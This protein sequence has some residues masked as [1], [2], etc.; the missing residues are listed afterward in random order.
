MS[1]S[2]RNLL[3]GAAAVAAQTFA[4]GQAFGAPQGT[5]G[6]A[7]GATCN[8]LADAILQD[9]PESATF[10]GLDK[11]TRAGLKSRLSDQSWFHVSK[12]RD[13]CAAWLGK[14]DAIPQARLSPA[15]QVDK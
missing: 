7:F 3:T 11:G 13:V 4:F 1:P 6:A 2:R 9:N 10:L 12:D 8:A 5:P 15:A 14:L